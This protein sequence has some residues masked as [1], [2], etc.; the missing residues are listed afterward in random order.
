MSPV[1]AEKVPPG[2]YLAD[3]V[4][5][6]ET[7]EQV[8]QILKVAYDHGVPV[9]PR[10]A[11]TGNYGQATPFD[12]GILLETTA[13]AGL[14]HDQRRDRDVRGRGP[15]EHGRQGAARG[16]PRHLDVPVDED[17]DGRRLRR[18]GQRRHGHDRA[19][20]HLRRLRGVRARRAV[21]RQRGDAPG[22]RRRARALRAHL[23]R[24]GDPRRRRGAHRPGAGVA[25]GL[26]GLRH[27]RRARRRAQGAAGPAGAPAAR[28]GR[29]AG[30]GPHAD[31]VGAAGPGPAQ[32]AG[33]RRG[34]DRRRAGRPGAGRRRGRRGR[35][36]A[37][38]RDRPALGDVVQPPRLV[39]AAGGARAEPVPHGDSGPCAVGRSRRGPRRLRR[40]G[41]PAPGAVRE[42][43]GRDGR[44]G[45]PR[46]GGAARRA[47]AV[48]GDRHGGALAPPVVRRPQRRAGPRDRPAHRPEGPAQPGQAGGRPAGGH[49]GEHRGAAV[50][51]A[52]WT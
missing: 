20:H 47:P 18:R 15:A 44:R 34:V 2:R 25:G 31:R 11:G 39:P 43:A 3:A 35:A 45:I 17:L 38:R 27:L 28:V 40:A 48:R 10:G 1:L 36:R 26:H 6:P 22:D 46:R 7:P 49:A 42:R 32:P 9:T 41:A 24:H 30:A 29:R 37:L 23:R 50:V 13:R 14:R 5:R 16:R 21:R 12:G 33:D 52:G 4:V 19:R 51:C 8:P